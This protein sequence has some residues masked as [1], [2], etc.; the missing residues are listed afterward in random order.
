MSVQSRYVRVYVPY[1]TSYTYM[2]TYTHIHTPAPR[3]YW[4]RWVDVVRA[5]D[6]RPMASLLDNTRRIIFLQDTGGRK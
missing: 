4:R 3:G 2:H 1:S 5:D 6:R